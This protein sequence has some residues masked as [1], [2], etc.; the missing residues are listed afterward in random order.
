MTRM[1]FLLQSI[2]SPQTFDLDVVTAQS[3]ENPVY[4][5]Q[6]AHAAHRVDRAQG[7]RARGWSRQPLDSVDLVVLVDERELELLRLLDGVPDAVADAADDPCAAEGR[8]LGCATSP[9]RSTA[10]TATAA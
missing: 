5:V 7:R 2:D 8:P 9:A 4:Y 1:T 3:M 10:S 6:Y